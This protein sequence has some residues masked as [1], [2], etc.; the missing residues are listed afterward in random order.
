MLITDGRPNSIEDLRAYESGIIDVATVERIDLKAKLGLAADEIGGEVLDFLVDE[1]RASDPRATD[2][3][4]LGI[5]DV[6]VTPQIKRW[7]AAQTL[8]VTYR[9][10]F[11]N[12]LNSRYRAQFEEYRDLAREF[13]FQALRF[14][15]GVVFQP[16][17]R[18]PLPIVGFAPGTIEATLFYVQVSWV[19]A[20]GAESEPSRQT[21]TDA[22]QYHLP[23]ISMDPES[24]PAGVTGFNVYMGLTPDTLAL[25]NTSPVALGD[26]FVQSSDVLLNGRA[27]GAG[28]EADMFVTGTRVIRRA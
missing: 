24:A 7:H 12:Q 5:F 26:I 10:A 16:I 8:A 21:T 6:V 20:G 25:Q 27:P 28:Q 13:R 18:A 14:G 9:D 4:R 23:S 22:V 3:R 17:P 2:R 11:H 1:G 15:V 19:G